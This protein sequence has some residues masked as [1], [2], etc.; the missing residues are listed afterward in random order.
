M[1]SLSGSSAQVHQDEHDM[2][3]DHVRPHIEKVDRQGRVELE[4][5][6]PRQRCPARLE[7]GG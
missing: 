5:R 3:V 2:V 1:R 6:F 4:V 7:A